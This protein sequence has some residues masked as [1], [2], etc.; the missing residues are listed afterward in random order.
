MNFPAFTML[1]HAVNLERLY[2]NCR[3]HWDGPKGVAK[4]IYR[5]AHHYLEAIGDKKGIYDAAVEVFDFNPSNWSG[6]KCHK[7]ETLTPSTDLTASE[8]LKKFR[9]ELRKR[10]RSH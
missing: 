1:G 6:Q 4:Q 10:L 7:Y 2:I 9:A 3:I 8:N 5:D